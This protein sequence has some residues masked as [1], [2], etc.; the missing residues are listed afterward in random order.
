MEYVVAGEQD[1]IRIYDLV[2]QTI[3][4]IY[5]KYYPAEVVGFFSNLH[6]LEAITKDVESGNTGIL[7]VDK[8]IVGTGSFVDNHITR[9]YVAP[10]QQGNGYGTFMIQTIENEIAKNYDKAYLD[11][12]LPAL[13]LYKKLGYQVVLR[14]KYPV[15]NGVL[16]EYEVMEKLV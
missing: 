11:A 16:L 10:D 13:N 3:Q 2:Q 4:S 1:I 8:K 12:S 5:P 14:E 7:V 9:V 6:S 15:E